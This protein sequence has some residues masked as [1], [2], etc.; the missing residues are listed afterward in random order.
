VLSATG[1]VRGIPPGSGLAAVTAVGYTGFLAGPPL[2]GLV[3]QITSL[4]AALGLVAALGVL[5]VVLAPA[6]RD[7]GREAE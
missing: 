7:G 4:R 6:V 5:I 3:A 2:I 1:R